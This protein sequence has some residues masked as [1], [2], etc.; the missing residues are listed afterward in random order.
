M[1]FPEKAWKTSST[2]QHISNALRLEINRGLIEVKYRKIK[3]RFWNSVQRFKNVLEEFN[4]DCF[5]LRMQYGMYAGKLFFFLKNFDSIAD[6]T[7]P[8][9]RLHA[10]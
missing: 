10:I 1:P 3:C 9:E 6:V 5:T 7:I 8:P 2:S 4:W